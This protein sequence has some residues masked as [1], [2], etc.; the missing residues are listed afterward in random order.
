MGHVLDEH[1]LEAIRLRR[2]ARLPQKPNP[3]QR[4]VAILLVVGEIPLIF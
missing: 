3:L 4:D 2:K 1:M